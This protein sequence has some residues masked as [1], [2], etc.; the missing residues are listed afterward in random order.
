ML[1][2]FFLFLLL[3]LSLSYDRKSVKRSTTVIYVNAAASGGDGSSWTQAYNNLQSALTAASSLS[4]VQIWV[5]KGTYK[6]TLKYGG[7]YSGTENNLVTFKLSSNLAI[8]GGFVGTE[9]S[10]SQRNLNVNPTILSGDINGDDPNTN[11]NAWHILYADGITNTIVDSFI[12]ERGFA[13]GPDAGTVI[14]GTGGVSTITAITY[15]HT[16]GAGL[17]ARN[18][19]KVTLNK[20]IIQNHGFNSSRATIVD[21][22]PPNTPLAAGG[23]I[24]IAEDG[25]LVTVTASTLTNNVATMFG[26]EGPAANLVLHG[27]L[28]ISAS[29]LS[30]NMGRENGGSIRSRSGRSI[31]STSNTFTNNIVTSPGAT[32]SGGAIGAFNTNLTVTSCIFDSNALTLLGFGGGGAILFHNPFDDGNIYKLTVTSSIFKNNIGSTFGGGAISVFGFSTNPSTSAAITSCVFTNNS[33]A[34]GGAISVDSLPTS[35][36]SCVFNSNKAWAAGGAISGINLFNMLSNNTAVTLRTLLTVTSSSFIS[37]SIVGTP[38]G[39]V[40]PLPIL[41]LFAQIL[42]P[43]VGSSSAGVTAL[44]TGGGSISSQFSGNISVISCSFLSNSAGTGRGGAILVGG[45]DGFSGAGQTAMERAYLSV[46]SSSGFGNTDSTGTN[47]VAVL[48]PASIGS[49]PG[50]VQFVTDGSFS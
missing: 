19:A 26:T 7:G 35:V 37:D 22:A 11:D 28:T 2:V 18:G 34:I 27:S 50:G 31:V 30:N 40:P 39:A 48:D 13:A 38:A 36:T 33:A 10:V 49:G 43:L 14:R 1:A 8:Y 9:T 29:T 44:G 12:I 16:M 45:S 32:T 20:V 15:A 42:A 5:A 6:P 23:A 46:T 17:V 21:L 41:N 3:N 4:G 47:N 25:T 24:G